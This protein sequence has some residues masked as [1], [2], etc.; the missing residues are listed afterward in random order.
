MSG[1]AA[2]GGGADGSVM[3]FDTIEPF[4]HANLGID[5]IIQEQK[6][7]VAKHNMTPGDL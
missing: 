7:F 1:C 4:Y 5:E 3:I 2:S 6:P